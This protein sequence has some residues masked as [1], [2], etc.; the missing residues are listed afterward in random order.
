MPKKLYLYSSLEVAEELCVM[1]GELLRKI[2]PEELSNGAWMKK[3]KVRKN[4]P[5]ITLHYV[6]LVKY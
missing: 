3:N 5:I 6:R 2:D 1:D 4:C